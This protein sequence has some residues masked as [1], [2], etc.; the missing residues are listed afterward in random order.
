MIRRIKKF[1]LA[2]RPVATSVLFFSSSPVDEIWTRTT[3][4]SVKNAGVSCAVVVISG[5]LDVSVRDAYRAAGIGVVEN[6]GR[7]VL[8]RCRAEIA[9]TASS[10]IPKDWFPTSAVWRIHMPHS[11]VSLHMIY[12]ADAFD[13]YNMLFAVGP[14]HV[15][16]FIRLS[17]WRRLGDRAAITVGYGKL[18]I[19]RAELA[20]FDA[21][22]PKDRQRH[23]LLAPSWGKTNIL[24][25]IG[26]D[27]LRTLLGRGYRVTLRPHPIFFAENDR[28]LKEIQAAFEDDKSFFIENSAGLGKAIFDAEVLVTDYSGT[29]QEFSV[30]RRRPVVFVDVAKKIL[31]AEWEELGLTPLELS[32]RGVLGPVAQPRTEEVVSCIDYVIEDQVSWHDRIDAFI[33]TFSPIQTCG[34]TA[35]AELVKLLN[36]LKEKAA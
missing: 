30:L 1:L 21:P 35:A 10:G 20:R 36:E 13:G 6:V 24:N 4:F 8:R 29:A 2:P 28:K 16:E 34:T 22:Q 12:P 27:L 14:H 33:P 7:H 5:V 3:T 17:N 23:I 31:N 25:T 32:S 11:I 19:L 9:V 18:D 26:L 15:N